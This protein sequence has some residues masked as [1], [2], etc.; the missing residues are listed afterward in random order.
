[1][2][3]D[4]HVFSIDYSFVIYIK[5][6]LLS[7]TKVKVKIKVCK[8]SVYHKSCLFLDAAK[9]VL[10][11]INTTI[12]SRKSSDKFQIKIYLAKNVPTNCFT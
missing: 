5:A 12:L 1:M 8:K 2:K 4:F 10:F 7:P 9:I 6:I 11:S 3:Q